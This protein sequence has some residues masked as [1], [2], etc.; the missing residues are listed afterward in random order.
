VEVIWIGGRWETLQKDL[1]HLE[2]F[3]WETVGREERTA[4]ERWGVV[5]KA[6]STARKT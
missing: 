6:K 1:E 2:R 3:L 5:T 4:L